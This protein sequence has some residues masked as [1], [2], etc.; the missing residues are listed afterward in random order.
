MVI[1]SLRH[2]KAFG[3]PD[4]KRSKGPEEQGGITLQFLERSK[5]QM[6]VLECL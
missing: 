6:S 2:L 4:T 3:R 1:M 5:S